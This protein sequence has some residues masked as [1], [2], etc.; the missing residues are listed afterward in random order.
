MDFGI[1]SLIDGFIN[2]FSKFYDSS[3]VMFVK[4]LM[5]I[6][7]S[8]LLADV[9]LLIML[10]GITSAMRINLRGVEIPVVSQSA[11]MKRWNKIKIRLKSGNPSQYKVAILEADAIA[12]EILKGMGYKGENMNERLKQIKPGQI[13]NLEDL[14]RAHQ[15]RNRIIYETDLSIEKNQATETIEIYENFLKDMEFM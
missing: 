15:T 8:V 4:F 7:T 11:M 1:L 13:D 3:F 14:N 12:D 10:V 6:Y 5:M 2:Y 9:I